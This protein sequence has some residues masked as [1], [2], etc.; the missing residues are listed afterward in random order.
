M[1]GVAILKQCIS[2]P[3]NSTRFPNHLGFK[4]QA[5]KQ[6]PL[7]WVR[8]SDNLITLFQ[9]SLVDLVYQPIN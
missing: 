9:S 4:S 1:G 8:K 6:N 3:I 5:D 2:I 7:N